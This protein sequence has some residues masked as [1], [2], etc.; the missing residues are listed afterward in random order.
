MSELK[1]NGVPSAPASFLAILLAAIPFVL[2][3]TGVSAAEVSTPA[4]KNLFLA[5]TALA[6]S[7]DGG[8]LYV[9]CE[10]T[11]EVLV[12]DTKAARIAARITVSDSPSGLALSA[13]G[14]LLYVT[15]AGPK[16]TV[17]VVDTAKHK[18]TGRWRAGYQAQS[19]VLSPDE[20]TLY[21]CNR[22]DNDIGV[23]D[24]ATGKELRR[25]AVPREPFA[26]AV[27]PDGK[28]LLVA[29]HLHAG[30]SNGEVVAATV[31]VIDCAAGKVTKEIP[32]P[33]GSM[34]L[35]EIQVSPDGRHAA[36]VHI[37]GRFHLP[38]TQ[39]ERGWINTSALSLI[40]LPKMSLLNTVL[41]DNI[42]AGAA[43][44]WAAAWTHDGKR[45]LVTHAATHELSIVDFPA[46]LA[47][48][49][50]MPAALDPNKPLDYTAASRTAAD[51]PNDLSFLVGTRQ[52]VRLSGKGPRSL[53]I[54]G[55]R[56][57]I[58]HYFSDVLDAVDFGTDPARTESHPL[59]PPPKMTA[60]R[61]G[62]LHF[63]DA[64]LCFQG[65]QSCSSCHSHDARVDGMNWDNLNDGIGNPKNAKSLLLAHA[66][67]P[68]M[69]LGVRTNA[70]V[71][72]RAGIRNSLFT[73]Q[74]PEVAD[75]LDEYLK[76]LKP[77]PSPRLVNGKLS[78]AAERGRKLF[79]SEAVGC[80]E[81]HSGKFFTDQKFHNVGTVG[82]YDQPSDKFDTP[83]LIEA[84]RTAPYLHDGSAATMR[85]VITSR[86]ASGDHGNVKGLTAEQLDDLAAYVLSL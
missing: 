56:A 54:A 30:R 6:A 50:K 71:A 85:D 58:A 13:D 59:G 36:V 15:C 49:E 27:T 45:L 69:W 51:V 82:K 22:F 39:I 25:I 23:L 78:P 29:N 64:T 63:N 32:L 21:V 47:R 12:F 1:T 46:L 4:E 44:P 5:P 84:W 26:A 57:W 55:G 42:N 77:M 7:P 24:R 75:Q 18:V 52:R 14:R 20:R 73:V 48:L 72:V 43:T 61:L 60:A 76:S 31:S 53:A 34:Q 2:P 9:A 81:C 19:P 79:S 65:W 38:T 80:A 83:T 86:N 62:E 70:Y 68:S 67:P 10:A 16:S 41:L 28:F 11:D 35:R 74:P 33:N 17:C 40:D 3:L 8:V 66:T 37:L